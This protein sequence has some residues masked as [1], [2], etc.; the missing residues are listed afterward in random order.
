MAAMILCNKPLE[1]DYIIGTALIQYIAHAFGCMDYYTVHY[2]KETIRKYIS[3]H[4]SRALMHSLT[5]VV[6]IA[7]QQAILPD[8]CTAL[9]K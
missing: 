5:N 3:E 8:M 7:D 2:S 4:D 1:N 6:V 9:Q